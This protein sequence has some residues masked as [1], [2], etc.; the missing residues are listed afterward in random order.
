MGLAS[1]QPEAP[2]PDPAPACCTALPP[3]RRYAKSNQ[4]VADLMPDV[5]ALLPTVIKATLLDSALS[6]DAV[7][8]EE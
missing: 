2:T 5:Q 6:S 7:V 8:T 3:R 4:Q 1:W